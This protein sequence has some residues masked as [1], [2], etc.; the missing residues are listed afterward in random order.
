[1]I[2]LQVYIGSSTLNYAPDDSLK[3]DVKEMSLLQL[4]K[5][6]FAVGAIVDHP[7]EID[8]WMYRS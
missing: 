4:S 8:C 5:V 7:K 1:M 2:C 6:R 3:F